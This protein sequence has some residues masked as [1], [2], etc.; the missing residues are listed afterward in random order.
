MSNKKGGWEK[1]KTAE[2]KEKKEMAVL[3]LTPTLFTYFST[4]HQELSNDSRKPNTSGG[5][6]VTHQSKASTSQAG[7]LTDC[8]ENLALTAS[9]QI[10]EENIEILNVT[11]IDTERYHLT[12]ESGIYI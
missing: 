6:D 2:E 9:E 3:K 7:N 11:R 4:K 8:Q 1:L 10:T 12:Q 5:T